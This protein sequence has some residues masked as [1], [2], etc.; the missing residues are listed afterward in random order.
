VS[1]VSVVRTLP[2]HTPLIE[3][4]RGVATTDTTDTGYSRPGIVEWSEQTK[5]AFLS[6]VQLH[7]SLPELNGMQCINRCAL[8]A[9][10][11][12]PH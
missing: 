3:F 12:A 10:D 1:V 6:T 11:H 2:S 5:I 4:S 7:F 8:L 9:L